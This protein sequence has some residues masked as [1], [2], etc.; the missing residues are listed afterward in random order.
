LGF[1][2]KAS[3]ISAGECDTVGITGNG[4]TADDDV[5]EVVYLCAVYFHGVVI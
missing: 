4:I 5:A 3:L 1:V 2:V